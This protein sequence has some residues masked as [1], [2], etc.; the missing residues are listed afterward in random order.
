MTSEGIGEDHGVAVWSSNEWRAEATAWIDAQLAEIGTD[1]TGAVEQPHLRPWS[2][3]LAVPTADGRVFFKATGP[4][5]AFEPRLYG[6]LEQV[7][8]ERILVPIAIDAAR[9]W[10]LL[11][12]GGLPLGERRTGSDLVSAME[13]VLPLYAQ[14]PRAAR[15][16]RRRHA[17][18]GH[19][20]ALRRGARGDARVH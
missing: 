6:L 11:P 5:V 8:P 1:R 12:D 16:G 2:T 20:A 19:A 13:S 9:G 10:V 18:R 7:V 17:A 4:E 15:S 3:I 14:R